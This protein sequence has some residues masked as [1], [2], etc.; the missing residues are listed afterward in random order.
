MVVSVVSFSETIMVDNGLDETTIAWG[1]VSP[2][3]V[4]KVMD[5]ERIPAVPQQWDGEFLGNRA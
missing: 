4:L 3:M 2:G 5:G 1:D